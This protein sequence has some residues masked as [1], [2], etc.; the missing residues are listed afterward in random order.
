V[1][2]SR[3]V[4]RTKETT[5]VPGT[6]YVP[7]PYYGGFYSYYYSAYP[8]V[9][10]PGYLVTSTIVQIETNLYDVKNDK[11]AWSA[12]SEV[13]DPQGDPNDVKDFS[14]MVGDRMAKEGMIPKQMKP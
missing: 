13:V 12:I 2:I 3:L 8:A 1:I 10:D 5:Y 14:I 7:A 11:L 4:D 6:S 9:Y